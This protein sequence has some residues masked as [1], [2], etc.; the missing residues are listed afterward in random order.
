MKQLITL[1]VNGES[2]EVWTSTHKTLLEVLREDLQLTGTKHGCELGE[3]GTCSVLIDGEPILSCLVLP[4][5][6][7]KRDIQTIEGLAKNGVP[8][9]LQTAFA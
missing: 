5:E 6:V 3:C 9:P 1:T 4:V 2:H 7:Q 8:H